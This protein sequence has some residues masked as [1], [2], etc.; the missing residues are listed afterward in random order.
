MSYSD[1]IVIKA[2][3]TMGTDE[4]ECWMNSC[5]IGEDFF[6][7]YFQWSWIS[8]GVKKYYYDRDMVLEKWNTWDEF[9]TVKWTR[10]KSGEDSQNILFSYDGEYYIIDGEFSIYASSPLKKDQGKLIIKR[11]YNRKEDEYNGGGTKTF[12]GVT[13]ILKKIGVEKYNG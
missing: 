9:R 11:G 13:N 8:A 1:E 6:G 3:F 12:K 5:Q 2:L 10:I 4:S 7:H